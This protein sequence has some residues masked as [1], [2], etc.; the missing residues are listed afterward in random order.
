MAR[1]W[2]RLACLAHQLDVQRDRL[3]DQSLDFR[4]RLANCD[5]PG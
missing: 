1:L 4:A 3:A 5:A 2:N